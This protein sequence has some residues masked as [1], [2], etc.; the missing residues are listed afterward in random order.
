MEWVTAFLRDAWQLCEGVS[1]CA[2]SP[3]AMQRGEHHARSP[4]VIRG[5]RY[6]CSG[7]RHFF[8]EPDTFARV[9]AIVSGAWHPCEEVSSRTRNLAVVQGAW[10][11]CKGVSSSARSPA[12]I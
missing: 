4:P 6:P 2:R 8:Q 11:L 5:A 12:A 9:G 7:L 10:H 1:S 3:A